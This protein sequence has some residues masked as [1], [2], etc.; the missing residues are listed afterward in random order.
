MF[1]E[2]IIYFRELLESFASPPPLLTPLTLEA[3][4]NTKQLKRAWYLPCMH[5][6]V[7]PH[8]F[9]FF[10]TTGLKCAQCVRRNYLR[11]PNQYSSK[12]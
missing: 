2:C 8:A 1:I 4:P 12:A 10:G 3:T 7:A 5:A 9:N 6:S 11:S